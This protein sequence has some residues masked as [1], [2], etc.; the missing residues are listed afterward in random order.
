MGS[1]DAH[2]VI[3]KDD[4]KALPP[5]DRD[6]IVYSTVNNLERRVFNIE[7]NLPKHLGVRLRAVEKRKV[8]DRGLSA[9]TGFLGGI[10]GILGLK[11]GGID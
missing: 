6:Y 3:S 4:F 11:L 9:V 5:D 7:D 8:W 2:M 10:A 1:K